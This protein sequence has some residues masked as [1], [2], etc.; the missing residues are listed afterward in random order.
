MQTFFEGNGR[1]P[2]FYDYINADW[3][4]QS[5]STVHCKNTCLSK[6][7]ERYLFQRVMSVYKWKIPE[8]INPYY[9][10][11]VLYSFGFI[12]LFNHDDYGHVAMYG[13]FEG[14]DLYYYPKYMLF[15]SPVFPETVKREINKD[16]VLLN[17]KGDFSGFQDIVS[18]YADQL[19]L[20]F[21][22][23]GVCMVNTK[24]SNVFACDNKNA[25]ESFKRMFDQIAGGDPSV[26]VDRNLFNDD[27]TP[28]WLNFQA[29]LGENYIIDKLLV[30][31]RKVVSLFDIEAGLNTVNTE[32]KERMVTAEAEGT[33]EEAKSRAEMWLQDLKYECKK[34]KKLLDFDIDVEFRVKMERKEG[35]KNGREG[36]TER[37]GNVR[38]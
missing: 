36:N 5:P 28:R 8:E 20:L 33:Q 23:A 10:K 32:K 12:G 21:E 13:G 15:K 37:N 31:V 30:D 34:A 9:F 22:D 11:W 24:L 17:L 26:F 14:Y 38:L 19:A 6:M 35:D 2:F 29:P 1:P 25:S 27:G 4:M 16:C 7:F 18:F 3:G